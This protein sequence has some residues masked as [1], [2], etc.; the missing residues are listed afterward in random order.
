MLADDTRAIKQCIDVT[1]VQMN[2]ASVAADML[3]MGVFGVALTNV[4]AETEMKHAA[5]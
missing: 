5:T 4:N 2:A 1:C 3:D